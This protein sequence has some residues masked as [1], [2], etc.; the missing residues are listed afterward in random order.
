M[1]SSHRSRALRLTLSI[2][3]AVALVAIVGCSSKN[4]STRADDTD[5]TTTTAQPVASVPTVPAGTKLRIGDQLDYLKT[6]LAVSGQDQDLPYELEYANFV[7]GPPMLQAFQGGALDGGF[8]ASTP[9]L[10]A[11]AGG[12]DISAVAG[13]A[14]EKGLGG[15]ITT[16]DSIK[17]WGDLK[18]KR[19]AYQRSTSAEAAVLTG[20]DEAGLTINDITTVDIP[21]TQVA[22]TIKSGA[23]DAGVSTEPLISMFVN[24]TPGGHVAI[25][26][27][28]I[29]DRAAFLI[30][31]N[32]SLKDE[33]VSAALAD[34]SVRVVKAFTWLSQNKGAL[35]E[36]VFAK[37][38]GLTPERALE[39]A[40]STGKTSFFELP[41]P[42]G[43]PQQK[44]ADLFFAAGQIPAELD[45][46]KEFDPRFN[47][48][49]AATVAELEAGS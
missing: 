2:A 12:Q 49:I 30:A 8:V 6:V 32:E 43:E 29:T 34:Y 10:F 22:A 19:V 1:P 26:A 28:N 15:L 9:V 44:L 14:P 5:A 38:Y 23:A 36:S 16:D 13:W 3:T 21:I 37:Q 42:I 20:L 4:A 7:G 47:E 33:A 11:Q 48:L 18:G 31:S 24:E 25:P 27:N 35:A 17:D 46:S 45:T 39:L 41:G 40:E